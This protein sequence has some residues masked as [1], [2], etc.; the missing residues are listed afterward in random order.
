M[1]HGNSKRA[2]LFRN[3]ITED[4]KLID[5]NDIDDNIIRENALTVFANLYG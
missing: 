1:R 5:V 2:E 4:F 3:I